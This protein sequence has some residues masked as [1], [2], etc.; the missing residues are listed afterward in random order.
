MDPYPYD[1][2][3]IE[4]EKHHPKVKIDEIEA[5]LYESN[6]P[7]DPSSQPMAK[8]FALVYDAML[9]Q[10]SSIE[11]RLVK[12]ENVLANVLRNQGRIGSRINVNCVYYGGQDS[13]GKYKTIRCL[14]DDRIHDASSVTL[15][16]CLSCTR[17]EP[18]LGQVYDILDDT[19]MNGTVFLD[20]MQMGY[21]NL[22]D[23]K[24]LN[25]VEKRCTSNEYANVNKEMEKPESQIK[26]WEESDKKIYIESLKKKITD[27]K[28][29]DKKIKEIKQEDYSFKMN[30]YEQDL[31]VQEP[32]VKPYPLEGIKARYKK[33]NLSNPGEESDNYL[34]KES[35][36]DDST[37]QD[38]IKDMTDLEKLNNGEWVDTR[39]EADTTEINKYSS[40][41][42]Y[43]EDFNITRASSG[44]GSSPSGVFGAEARKKIV[45]KAKEIVQLHAE[46]KAGYSQG[47]PP[48]NRTVND[49]HRI[50]G[51]NSVLS[52]VV[53]YDCSSFVS[54]CYKYAGLNS[55]YNKTTYDQVAAM[56][57]K[58]IPEQFWLANAEGVKKALPGDL[59]FK[60][61]GISMSESNIG[62]YVDTEHV[63]IYIGD[64]KVAHASSGKR[65]VPKQIPIDNVDYYL[66]SRHFF[67]RPW[68]LIEADK[69]AQAN[70][71]IGGGAEAVGNIVT[72]KGE[73]FGYVYSFPKAVCSGYTDTNKGA[74]G[75]MCVP[76]NGNIVAAHNIPYETIVY[77]K[78]LDGKAGG[79]TV[80]FKNWLG[81]VSHTKNLGQ[82]KN[83]VF[84][85]GDTG[86]PY[87]DFDICTNAFSQK[88]NMD[89][90]VLEWGKSKIPFWSFTDAINNEGSRFPRYPDAIRSYKRM[91]GTTINFFK[92]KDKDKGLSQ[93]SKWTSI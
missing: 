93:S 41:D 18:I 83:G 15:D 63:M 42:Y 84:L 62:S 82:P 22:D 9:K 91:N 35:V 14:C 16:Q 36:L 65:P 53:V 13:F 19:G 28:E 6:H 67:A 70:G 56:T 50:I 87:F 92:F 34:E 39:E 17:Y 69:Q 88:T 10:S 79:G 66:N 29:L 8:N 2:K 25:R 78:E 81:V 4:L 75:A 60:T 40:E 45:E 74:S 38:T 49:E 85:V 44:V 20:N 37:D 90:L 26:R 71:V 80:T 23:L 11:K 48:G 54:C 68:D 47:S 24:N 55:M 86:G 64:N 57:S 76:S 32:D 73:N 7:G 72:S 52:N 21:M 30:W 3:I 89:V 27:E 59:M 1:D 31:D 58:K 61:S 33:I 12:I 51:S 43:F 77:I 46:G 5:R